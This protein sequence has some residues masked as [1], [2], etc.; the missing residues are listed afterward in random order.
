MLCWL[1]WGTLTQKV[2]LRS[3]AR[4]PA[5][6]CVWC[7]LSSRMLC[8]DRHVGS[9]VCC[10]GGSA[11]TPGQA[12]ARGVT[13]L[14]AF[15]PAPSSASHTQRTALTTQ[16]PKYEPLTTSTAVTS[17]PLTQPAPCKH[18]Q[19]GCIA[20]SLL[21]LVLMV[22]LAKR[23]D[24]VLRSACLLGD[25]HRRENILQQAKAVVSVLCRCMQPGRAQTV[26]HESLHV[27]MQQA[28][29]SLPLACSKPSHWLHDEL[30]S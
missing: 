30:M 22:R 29:C 15:P 21:V 3:P 5:S 6:S 18:A 16:A 28:L 8:Q 14:P 4:S 10:A 26:L 7:V 19:V 24:T 9:R 1:Y 11:C 17:R 27:A 13:R 12:A 20:R 2:H 23:H 25:L